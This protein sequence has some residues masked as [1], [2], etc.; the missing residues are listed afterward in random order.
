MSFKVGSAPLNSHKKNVLIKKVV[1]SAALG[2]IA[3]RIFSAINP[4]SAVI[5]NLTAKITHHFISALFKKTSFL[6]NS[7]LTKGFIK[8]FISFSTAFVATNLIYKFTLIQAFKVT[9]FSVI[10]QIAIANIFGLLV[11]M[12]SFAIFANM[13]IFYGYEKLKSLKA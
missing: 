13:A 8:S 3:G 12:G 10:T 1:S 4:F 5:F 7:K 2:Y 9:A 6:K 11:L